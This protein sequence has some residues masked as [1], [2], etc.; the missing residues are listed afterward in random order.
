[1]LGPGPYG[2]AAM[3]TT[4]VSLGS[5]FAL[6][7]MDT[8]YT[9]LSLQLE[10]RNRRQVESFCWRTCC[11]AALIGAVVI[12]SAWYFYGEFWLPKDY[13][14]VTA[15]STFAI[16]LFPL[17]SLATARARIH[18]RYGRLAFAILAGA[19]S[20]SLVSISVAKLWRADAF[21]L[22][23]GYISFPLVTFLILGLPR[24][25]TIKN[26]SDI[27]PETRKLAWRFGIATSI[28]APAYWI[29]SSADRWFLVEFTSTSQVGIYS[30]S[31]SIALLGLILNT[32]L[33]SVWLPEATRAYEKN[34]VASLESLGKT[35]QLM[36][37]LLALIWL[38]VTAA[39]GDIIRFLTPSQFHSGAQYIP[40]LAGGVFF[41]GLATLCSA[42]FF[43]KHQ[44]GKLALLWLIS[45]LFSLFLNYLLVPEHGPDGAALV[46]TISFLLLAVL[47][48]FLSRKILPFP[49]NWGR[50]VPCLILS[51]VA[52]LIMQGE[53]HMNPLASMA[54]KL[55][56]GVAV[57]FLVCRFINFSIWSI[58][59]D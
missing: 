22:L 49:T 30:T 2:V 3:A 19:I 24:L 13:L 37:T 56:C 5:I 26:A 52:G 25:S 7:G 29:I 33:N 55:P 34:Q 35:W 6:L 31:A 54:L 44:M 15:Y 32:S 45:A 59:R 16:I 9:R 12:G 41:Y 42:P 57:V 23:L 50:L 43:I 10:F 47:V 11:M 46:Q 53:W 21:T 48:F 4:V 40:W 58:N 17:V 8:A 18:E 1:M 36:I 20:S 39:G 14:V 51:L 28:T 27:S 38:T